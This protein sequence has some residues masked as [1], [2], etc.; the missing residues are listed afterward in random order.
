MRI[1]IDIDDTIAKFCEKYKASSLALD[2]LY[3]GNKGI[4]DNSKFM[5]KGMFY[6]NEN[7]TMLANEKT[8]RAII[9]ILRAVKDANKVIKQLRE[10]GHEVIFVSARGFDGYSNRKQTK[11]WLKQNNF[12]YDKLITHQYDKVNVCKKEKIDLFIDDNKRICDS[13]HQNGITV[14]RFL[15]CSIYDSPTNNDGYISVSRWEEIYNIIIEKSKT[16]EPLYNYPLILDTDTANEIDDQFAI[17]YLMKQSNINLEAITIAPYLLLNL[18]DTDFKYTTEKSYKIAK[19][20]CGLIEPK[21]NKIYKGC[22]GFLDYNKN[23]TSPAV[24]KIIEVA[25][26]NELTFI[27]CVAAPT[28]IAAAIKQKPEIK[29]KIKVLWLGGNYLDNIE[30]KEL[31]YGED[32]AATIQL[33]TSGVD[34]TIFPVEPVTSKLIISLND[35]KKLKNKNEVCNYLV[36]NA[37]EFF[38]E[39]KIQYHSLFDIAPVA[40][41]KNRIWFEHSYYKIKFKRM[42]LI[43]KKTKKKNGKNIYKFIMQAENNSVVCDMINTITK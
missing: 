6:W 8:I 36:K 26:K 38:T 4:K 15:G 23:I 20:I 24:E 28:N 25:L 35:I 18:K 29:N 1:G 9:P 16:Q 33:L 39:K 27:I 30:N 42:Q 10:N 2:K 22:E 34:V 7:E 37:I 12:E 43:R 21:F 5:T 32:I 41:L 31:N 14:V 13:L 17:G 40:Y 19:D 3:F 11:K